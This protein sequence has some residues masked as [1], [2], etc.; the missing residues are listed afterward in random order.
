MKMLNRRAY[1]SPETKEFEFLFESNFLATVIS[2]GED[3]V[4]GAEE[5][6]TEGWGWN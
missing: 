4:D 2:E 1:Q 5:G 6:E 3:P